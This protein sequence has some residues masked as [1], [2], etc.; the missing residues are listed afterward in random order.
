M[1][2]NNDPDF[3]SALEKELTPKGN[4]SDKAEDKGDKGSGAEKPENKEAA[5]FKLPDGRMVTPT[6]AQRLWNEEFM[7]DY[8]KKAQEL[9]TL[10]KEK[11]SN[12]SKDKEDADGKEL[13]AD[14]QEVIRILDRTLPHTNYG[15]KIATKGDV[16]EVTDKASNRTLAQIEL[17]EALTDLE[18]DFDGTTEK[19]TDAQGS[20]I[21]VTK[22]KVTAEEVANYLR[23]EFAKGNKPS[24]SPLQIAHILHPDEF[25]LYDAARVGAKV[26]AQ[27]P[28][29]EKGGNAAGG[30][31][32]PPQMHYDFGD[33]SIEK[34]LAAFLK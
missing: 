9:S 14:D 17:R 6:E 28:E 2:I 8:T 30:N 34:G 31:K 32:T 15:K 20:Q 13:S 16:E 1:P 18:T 33:D 4:E 21:S 5:S 10:K 19:L 27:L 29:T 22:P 11:S 3:E 23:A 12:Q 25:A 26:S 24:L 7:P